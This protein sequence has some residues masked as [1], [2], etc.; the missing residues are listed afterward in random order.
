MRSRFDYILLFT[1]FALTAIGT[2]MV[3]SASPTM[4]LKLGDSYYFLKRHI[5]YVLLGL[6]ALY[7]GLSVDL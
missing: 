7:L 4:A 3:F 2:I 1:T 5:L 6:G